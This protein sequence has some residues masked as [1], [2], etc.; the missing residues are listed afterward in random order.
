MPHDTGQPEKNRTTARTRDQLCVVAHRLPLHHDDTEGWQRA[1]G[2]LVS[3]LE[4]SLEATGGRWFGYAS[5][6]GP[7]HPPQRGR[8]EYVALE[9]DQQTCCDAIDGCCNRTLWPALHGLSGNVEESVDWWRSYFRHNDRTAAEVAS[10]ARAGAL[11]WVHDY[12]Y[13][14]IAGELKRLRRD[15]RIGLFCHTPFDGDEIARLTRGPELLDHLGRFDLIG[16]QTERDSNLLRAQFQRLGIDSQVPIHSVPV[17]IDSAAWARR[18]T[19]PEVERLARGHTVD[20]GLLAVGVDRADYTK[21]IVAKLLAFEVAL[22]GE[23][24]GP[25]DLRLLQVATPTRSGI[26]AYDHVTSEIEEIASRINT[27]FVRTDGRQ[28]IELERE[29]RSPTE[30][31]GL[32]R[33]ADVMVITPLRDGMNLVAVESSIVNA[34]RPTDMILSRGAGVAEYIGDHCRLVDGA[35]V[36]SIADALSAAVHRVP[37]DR[38]QRERSARRAEA[39]ARLS[40]HAWVDTSIDLLAACNSRHPVLEKATRQQ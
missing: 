31:A 32:M 19:D 22:H 7:V 36:L 30:V 12:H 39:A 35:D 3:A 8:A 4:S 5:G 9:I 18:R 11:V 20:E 10:R 17:G 15:L 33:A 40:S 26:A 38:D 23:L 1:P 37:S 34:D 24:F 27:A 21:G 25:D 14:A 13:F 29:S 2:G 28:V 16:M 6:N